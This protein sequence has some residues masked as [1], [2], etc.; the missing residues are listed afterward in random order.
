MRNKKELVRFG[1]SI[2]Q[3]LINSFDD[4]IEKCQYGNRSEAI[5]D[6]IRE[7]LVSQKW[8]LTDSD[9]EVAAT[10]TFVYDHHQRELSNLLIKIQHD[11]QGVVLVSQHIHLDHHN[12]LEVIILKGKS[13]DII[14]LSDNI[15]SLKG[16]K[17]CQL[18]MTTTG[19]DLI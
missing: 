6:L 19:T 13:R 15:K 14:S 4:Y 9:S 2:P 10:L 18:A 17:H 12:C 11:Y 7:K 3:D 8:E 5:R 1:V 16:I